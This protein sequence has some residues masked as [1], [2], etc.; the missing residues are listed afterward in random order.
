MNKDKMMAL[1][2]KRSKESGVSINTLLLLYFFEHFLERI[3]AS[4]YR[5]D[6]ILKGGFLL[7]SVLGIQ[8]RTTMDMDISLRN[9]PLSESEIKRFF[10]NWPLPIVRM[11]CDIF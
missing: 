8:T 5:T 1:I 11:D 4:K 7:S 2:R 10:Q 6:L 3:A 9:H